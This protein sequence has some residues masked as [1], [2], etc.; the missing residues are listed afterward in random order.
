MPRA[1]LPF[2]A[3]LLLTPASAL[4]ETTTV[5][6]GSSSNCTRG[7]TCAAI[8]PAID[9]SAAG[10]TVRVLAGAYPESV[11]ADKADLVIDGDGRVLIAPPS[12]PGV[13][14][15][16]GDLTLRD[17]TVF[18]TAAALTVGSGTDNRVQRSTLV[19]T[20]DGLQVDAAGLI[21]DSSI[22]LG[23]QD[24]AAHRVTTS[25]GSADAALTLN[26]VTTTGSG[27]ALV[28]DGDGG[29]IVPLTPGDISF[30][31]ASSII[32]GPSTATR[33]SGVLL[34]PGN[35]V[36][37][38]YANSDATELTGIEATGDGTVT[39]DSELFGDR[40]R[41]RADSPAIGRGG[42]LSAGESDTDI[43]GDARVAGTA[44]DIGA[45]EFVNQAPALTLDVSPATAQTGEAITAAGL[46]KDREGPSD[47][48]GYGVD[49]GDGTRTN[50]ADNVVQHAYD[51]AGTFEVK[52]VAVDRSG[53]FS[54][55][56]SRTVT[57]TD[58]TPPQLLV[59][60]PKEGSTAELA[61]RT[62]QVMKVRG[63]F[64]DPSGAERI[65]VAITR[66]TGGCTHYDGR[67]FVKGACK[68]PR[69]LPATIKGTR[70]RVDTRALRF[71]PG[72]YLVRVKAT[73]TAGNATSGFRKADHTLVAFK[74][75]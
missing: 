64:A 73:D 62:P 14:V 16:A 3:L 8:N 27:A 43:D 57:I 53:A 20:T 19:G 25:P 9:V 33:F 40:L 30:T 21:V 48:A 66:R 12:G 63:V 28:L 37:A 46:A 5:D 59:T 2:L 58:G 39:P 10:D 13:A 26:H 29:G 60:R 54:E 69:L 44:S 72:T 32:H 17:V 6:P 52:M 55:V 51:R 65:E 1:L 15:T 36:T 4:A 61:G 11:T 68:R 31:A 45:D 71:K 70:F 7:G 24:G 56:A 35:A 50:G 67:R 38:S 41:L 74:V 47:I 22:V 75:T 49:W 42:P 34:V 23:G 18:S